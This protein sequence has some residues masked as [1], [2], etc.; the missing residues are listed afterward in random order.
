MIL[1]VCSYCFNCIHL[2]GFF[3]QNPQAFGFIVLWFLIF[4]CQM[5]TFKNS[6]IKRLC[7]LCELFLGINTFF[8]KFIFP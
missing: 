8:L 4:L 3:W 6:Y 2:K 5:H 1:S 7:L